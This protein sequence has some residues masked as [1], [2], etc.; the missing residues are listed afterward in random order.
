MSSEAS[1]GA[2]AAYFKALNEGRFMIQRCGECSHY[3]FHPRQFCPHCDSEQL[4]WVAPKGT[5][6]VYSI[7]TIRRKAEAGGDYNISLID[8]DEGVRV[9]SRVEGVPAAEVRIGMPVSAEVMR[10]Q[11]NALLV[12]RPINAGG[13]Q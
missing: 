10:R 2:E 7:T 9:L 5:G 8:L 3:I 1:T 13:K 11:D 4:Q 12:F 6:T